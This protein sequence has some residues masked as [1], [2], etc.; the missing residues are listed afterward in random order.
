V[1]FLLQ[2]DDIDPLF[3]PYW[4]SLLSKPLVN[5]IH[6]HFV[7]QDDAEILHLDDTI[8]EA[9][10]KEEVVHDKSA[11]VRGTTTAT[12]AT[13]SVAPVADFPGFRSMSKPKTAIP[14]QQRVES[15]LSTY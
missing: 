5:D 3:A 6:H 14:Q 7:I 2:Q 9:K 12:K 4:Q 8:E 1:D 13:K 10:S 11:T 15:L